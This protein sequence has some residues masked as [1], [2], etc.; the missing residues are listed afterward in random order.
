MLRRR[1]GRRPCQD[2]LGPNRPEVTCAHSYGSSYT[3]NNNKIYSD[4]QISLLNKYLNN[5]NT[6]YSLV[7][8]TIYGFQ[9]LA[10]GTLPKNH[11]FYFVEALLGV[12]FE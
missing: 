6:I 1:H 12:A 7:K 5:I 10:I 4:N 11:N 3:R 2:A 8:G 9:L